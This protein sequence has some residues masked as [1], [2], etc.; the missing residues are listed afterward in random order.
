MKMMKS[1]QV[2]AE[3]AQDISIRALTF[4]TSDAAV[5]SRFLELTG[6]TPEALSQPGSK[7]AL[8]AAA[9]D[10]LMREEDLLLTFA[11]NA[12]IDPLVVSQ[13]H[14]ALLQTQGSEDGTGD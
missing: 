2:T 14:R 12:G 11:A 3:L 4:L 6:W 8:L 13:A 10:H 7:D 9:L 1:T 5:L